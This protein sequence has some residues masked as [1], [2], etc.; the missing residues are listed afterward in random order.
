MKK[1]V[2]SIL[3]VSGSALA[4]LNDH[5]DP[6]QIRKL[7]VKSLGLGERFY[8][9]I[10]GGENIINVQCLPVGVGM[11][12]QMVMAREIRPLDI[13]FPIRPGEALQ[14]ENTV[15]ICNENE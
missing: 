13:Q 1:V 3:L 15:Y 8:G 4:N 10:K 9:S 6:A 2:F 7:T 5:I 14:V 12:Y 11:Q